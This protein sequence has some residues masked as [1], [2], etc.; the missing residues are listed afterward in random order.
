MKVP[1]RLKPLLEDELIEEVLGQLQ[2][3]KEAEVYLVRSAGVVCCAKVYKEAKNRTFKQRAPYTEGRKTRNSRQARAMGSNSKYGRQ[4]RESEWQNTE[5]ETLY[6]LNS[7]GVSVPRALAFHE[8]VLLLELVTD[9]DGNPAPRLNDVDLTREQA[10]AFHRVMIRQAVLMLCAGI[11]HGDLSEFNV[12][13]S[14]D[15]LVIIDLPQAVQATASNAFAIFERD[16]S[17][18]AAYFGRFAPEIRGTKHA[19]EIWK[20]YQG[21]TLRPDSELTGRYVDTSKSANLRE[22]LTEIDSAR[23]E[24]L[25]RRRK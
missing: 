12:L 20:L 1:S 8:G 5:V 3:G 6:L 15:G 16:L 4:E 9:A 17:Q 23:E 11:V 2:S 22:V 19:K 18:L 25:E 7:A 24:A 13:L 14:K 10:R 21:G